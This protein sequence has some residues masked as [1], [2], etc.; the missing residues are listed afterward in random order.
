M[1]TRLSLAKLFFACG[2]AGVWALAA[3]CGARTPLFVL[4]APP[5]DAAVADDNFARH[6]IDAPVFVDTLPPPED[7]SLDALPP[8]DVAPVPDVFIDDCPDPG[9]TLVYVVGE[10]NTLYSFYPPTAQFMPLGVLVRPTTAAACPDGSPIEPFSM[11]VDKQG[12]AY[13][14]F[15]DGELFQVSTKTAACVSTPYMPGQDGITTFGMGFV[16]NSSGTGDTLYV[17]PDNGAGAS[18]LATI[19]TNT[20]LLSLIG[21]FEPETVTKAELSGTGDGRLFAFYNATDNLGEVS[22][23][24]AQVDPTNAMVVANNVLTGVPQGQGW[25]FA[26]WGGKFYLFTAPAGG[27]T[28]TEFD[29]TTLEQTTVAS[30]GDIIVGAGVSTCAPMQ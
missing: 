24:V 5:V 30:T 16:G 4:D 28:V 21:T 1:R 20:F 23:A 22:S 7:I 2:V 29:P 10:S 9:A 19:D 26:F 18:Q 11:A 25:A 27:T 3:A 14:V 15:C 13:V 12:T 8:I 17:A 6:S